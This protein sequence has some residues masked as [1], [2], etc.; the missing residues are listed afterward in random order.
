MNMVEESVLQDQTKLYTKE[1]L[2]RDLKLQN[3]QLSTYQGEGMVPTVELERLGSRLRAL[4]SYKHSYSS[5][6]VETLRIA[7]ELHHNDGIPISSLV[8]LA[9]S[10]TQ[11]L[12]YLIPEPLDLKVR[13][14]M[15]K[16]GFFGF[17]ANTNLIPTP[18]QSQPELDYDPMPQLEESENFDV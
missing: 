4:G 15:V 9:C 12:R 17:Y 14:R 7:E 11:P 2:L 13:A 10:P 18:I 16:K 8:G 3:N 1:K 5:E 6:T